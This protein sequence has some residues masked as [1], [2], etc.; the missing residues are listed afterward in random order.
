MKAT[1]IPIFLSLFILTG[2]S[3]L[4]L[5]PGDFAWPVVIPFAVDGHGNVQ[6]TRY[7]FSLNVKALLFAETQ[8]SV[9]ISKVTLWIIRDVK[10]YYFITA[11]QFKNVYVFEQSEGGLILKNKIFVAQNGLGT[12]EF[13]QREPYIQL[14]D[15]QNP[16]IML[17]SDGVVEGEKK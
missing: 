7:S 9:N 8:D 11:S 17:S 5:K 1:F 12:P 3:T 2:C 6:S 4:T 10:G 13:N 16:A 14:V 15:G